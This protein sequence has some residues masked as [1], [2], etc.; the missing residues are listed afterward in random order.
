MGMSRVGGELLHNSCLHIDGACPMQARVV[1]QQQCL[2]WYI[3]VDHGESSLPQ[4]AGLKVF[5]YQEGFKRV[6]FCDSQRET[7]V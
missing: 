4:G 6:V 1:E 3:S 7:L 2:L 5:S